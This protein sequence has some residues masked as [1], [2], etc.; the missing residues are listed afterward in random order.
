MLYRGKLEATAEYLGRYNRLASVSW[1][2]SITTVILLIWEPSKDII[3]GWIPDGVELPF[4]T[5]AMGTAILL[6]FREFLEGRIKKA[7]DALKDTGNAVLRVFV[8]F[9][10]LLPHLGKFYRGQ[11]NLHRLGRGEPP[12]PRL[13]V[14]KI[15]CF[16]IIVSLVLWVIPVGIGVH[17]LFINIT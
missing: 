10:P 4:Y 16:S 11:E 2:V 12:D 6:K 9:V 3:L 13:S 14:N 5:E 8:A 7:W 17:M 15:N 1:V